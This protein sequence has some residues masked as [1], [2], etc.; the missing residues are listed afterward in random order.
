[1][2]DD[3]ERLPAFPETAT[4]P[5][6]RGSLRHPARQRCPAAPPLPADRPYDAAPAAI[7]AGT[8][9][10]PDQRRGSFPAAGYGRTRPTGAKQASP[11]GFWRFVGV[12]TGSVA[13]MVCVS[14]YAW[15]IFDD[16]TSAYQSGG[17]ALI[18]VVVS[19]LVGATL[20]VALLWRA[21]R[22]Y[23]KAAYVFL[24]AT[25]ILLGYFMLI[26]A[27]VYRQ[28]NDAGIAEYQAS[29]ALFFFGL[30]TLV[31][32]IILAA[33][34]LRWALEPEARASLGRWRR[35]LGA[36]YGVLLGL[37]GLLVIA[38]LG[39]VLSV[40]SS[41]SSDFEAEDFEVV[42][43][44][45]AFTALAMQFFVPGMILVYHGIRSSIGSGTSP[46]RPPW[47]LAIAVVFGAVLLVGQANMRLD[48]PYGWPMPALHTLAAV[49][50]GAT[51]IAFAMRASW[52]RGRL[53][54]G[55][56]WRQITLAWG[57]AI[58]V[59]AM[60]AGFVNSIGG[61]GVTVLLLVYNGAFE[62]VSAISGSSFEYDAWDVIA[63][64]DIWL[65]ST[66]QWIANIIA[67][68]I[69][70]PFAEEFLKGLSVLFLLRRTTTRGQA[71]ALGA[72][73]GAGFGFV[74][75]LLYGAGVVADDL[76]AWWEIML[77]RAGSTS[78]HCLATG[79]V[80]LGWWYW[81]NG[82]DKR[83]AISLYFTAVI[84][85][86]IWNG[87]AVTL[88]SEILWIGTLEDKTIE[89]VAYG[90]VIVMAAAFIWTI[91]RIARGLREPPPPPVADTPLGAMRPW[92]AY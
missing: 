47:A 18:G 6:C 21:W 76:S 30:L 69:I 22:A 31:G 90:F 26:F 28:I 10:R 91:P 11:F 87:F 44:V 5:Y 59:G 64:A 51:Y 15:L 78:L 77:I 37:L 67:I 52:L 85:H 42:A 4:C 88:D 46:F 49:L 70:P 62:D 3:D 54:K 79:L 24:A 20:G 92:M 25:L 61:L 48:S 17:S 33:L 35:P 7:S 2:L 14:V 60:M 86:A 23:A 45:I 32:G 57:L 55:I 40:A 81:M 68:A 29:N 19:I 39:L 34:C 65:T 58:A 83:R 56:T 63:D 73:A 13:L 72:A 8:F 89:Y 41:E 36:A 9:A 84:L 43:V 12:S 53:V 82:G 74:E 66:Q 75:A 38:T 16:L 71:F 1:M 50:P 27:P 80:G